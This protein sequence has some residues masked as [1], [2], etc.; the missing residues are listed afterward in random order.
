[1]RKIN[2]EGR[3]V[4]KSFEEEMRVDRVVAEVKIDG[5]RGGEMGMGEDGEL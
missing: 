2:A 3:D 4:G 1:M 5:E